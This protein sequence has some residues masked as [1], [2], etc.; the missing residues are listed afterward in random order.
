M[1]QLFNLLALA[2]LAPN[3]GEN[4]AVKG[5]VQEVTDV[6]D[7]FEL[8]VA[9]RGGGARGSKYMTDDIATKIEKMQPKQGIIVPFMD[10]GTSPKRHRYAL[11]YRVDEWAAT[12]GVA[13]EKD[14]DGRVL[15]AGK[16][17]P[18]FS[19]GIIEGKG[20]GIR[21]DV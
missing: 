21:R 15:K 14:G 20:I 8:P 18:K 16:P 9:Q 10:D 11:K 17:A 3:A 2:M 12:Q 1:K 7:N 19:V 4:A 13:E 5:G 6:I